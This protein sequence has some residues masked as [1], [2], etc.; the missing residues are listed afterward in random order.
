[1][2][3]RPELGGLLDQNRKFGL[4]SGAPPVISRVGMSWTAHDLDHFGGAVSSRHR[5]AAVRPCID[6]AMRTG[7]VAQLADVDLQ[8]VDPCRREEREAVVSLAR[9]RTGDTGVW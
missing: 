1:M 8:H 7:L 2:M 6:V 4:S 9:R 5:L 3:R